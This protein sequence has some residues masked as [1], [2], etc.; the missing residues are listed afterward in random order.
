MNNKDIKTIS[1]EDFRRLQLLE[2]EMLVEFDRVCRKH[3]ISY[4][5]VCGT[6]LGAVRH[7]GFIPWDDDAD[8]AMLREDYEKFKKISKEMNQDICFFQDHDTDPEYR[9]GYGKLRHTNTELIRVGQRHLKCK[10]G[11]YVDI[12]PLDDIPNS[13]PGQMLND[14][15]CF[16]LRKILWAEVGKYDESEKLLVRKLYSLISHIPAEFVFKRIKKM[17]DKSRNSSKKIVRVLML[18]SG[19]KERT[20]LHYSD[21]KSDIKYRYG[22][23]KKV[24]TKT[25]DFE[26]E[27]HM[28]KGLKYYDKYLQSRYGNYMELPPKEKRV[29]KAPVCEYRF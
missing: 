21:K 7:K 16:I 12:M 10:T 29:G 5:M 4:C 9:W 19:A 1:G 6:L 20:E 3:N 27:G 2:L 17:A 11:V 28:F 23:P 14:F 25:R 26:F 18:P 8:I 15:Y 22:L 24:Y 13:I